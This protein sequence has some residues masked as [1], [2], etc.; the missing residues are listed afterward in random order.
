ME[1][2]GFSRH[3]AVLVLLTAIICFKSCASPALLSAVAGLWVMYRRPVLAI[4]ESVFKDAQLQPPQVVVRLQRATLCE[5]QSLVWLSPLI[6]TNLRTSHAPYIF[7]ADASPYAAGICQASLDSQ[8][9]A[10]LYR[11][12]Q[13]RGFYTRLEDPAGA[14]LRELGL[15]PV[16][17]FGSSHVADPVLGTS[18]PMPL[19]EGYLFDVLE[20]F[21]GEATW[22]RAH[23]ECGFTA[24]PGVDVSAQQV[25][26]MDMS[27]L[28]V[29]RELV[30]SKP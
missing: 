24:H 13:Q 2:K 8:V 19:R 22:T 26:A 1:S 3:L 7:C 11:R 10:E 23:T 30:A 15:D 17:V 16:D 12:S 27:Q 29:V 20:V 6:H 4:L 14:A 21:A 25:R 5:L 18:I 9:V 28:G